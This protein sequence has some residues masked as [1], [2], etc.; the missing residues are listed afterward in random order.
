[1]SE[2]EQEQAAIAEALRRQLE[3]QE[4]ATRRLVQT[5]AEAYERDGH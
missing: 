3:A 1:M 2:Q 5:M 4:E